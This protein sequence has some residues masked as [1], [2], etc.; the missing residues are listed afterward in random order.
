MKISLFIA[1]FLIKIKTLN[2]TLISDSMMNL[3]E[4]KINKWL[5]C[6]GVAVLLI[7]TSLLLK[8]N[9]RPRGPVEIN[10]GYRVVM[11]TLAQITVIA[12]S[13]QRGREYI[14]AAFEKIRGIENNMSIYRGDSQISMINRDAFE[15]P[16]QVGDE[17]FEIIERSI[18][19]GEITGGAF[20][21]TIGPI[22]ELYRSCEKQNTLPTK[23]QIARA[24]EK[25]GFEKLIIDKKNKSIRF[26]VEGMKIDLGGIAKG[27]AIDKAAEVLMNKG[28]MGAMIDVGGDI[29]CFIKPGAKR[30]SWKIGL[31][32]PKKVD[33]SALTDEYFLALE[34]EN[35]AVTTSGDYRRFVLIEGEKFSHIIDPAKATSSTT[36]SSVTIIA[37]S[38]TD[39]D[40]LATAVSVMGEE[41]GLELIEKT[42][43]TEAIIISAGPEFKLRKTS[44]A[45]AYTKGSNKFEN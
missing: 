32:N 36:L 39:A 12:E 43:D 16:V 10:S 3:L 2:I 5:I 14:E 1:V 21:I 20:D 37:S 34:L 38:A 31:Q 24:K 45:D 42:K 8:I 30:K 22:E 6:S 15:K 26:S 7:T 41:K 11:G 29:R 4:H 35:I 17:L 27:F 9:S 33:K 28:A 13:G 19:F 23:E 44:N 18:E 40:A 25:S